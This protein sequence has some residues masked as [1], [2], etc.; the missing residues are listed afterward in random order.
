[1]GAEY[2]PT[3]EEIRKGYIGEPDHFMDPLVGAEFDRWLAAH[4]ST[5]TDALGA[6]E[7]RAE[8]LEAMFND[9]AARKVKARAE[10]DAAYAAGVAEG[11]HH[12]GATD[13]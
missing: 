9:Q 6:A 3:T 11:I 7:K 8:R 2:T 1:M 10:R 12:E 4:V 13:E 5:L